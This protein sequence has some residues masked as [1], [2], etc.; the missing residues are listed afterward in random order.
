M[1]NLVGKREL[2]KARKRAEIVDIATRS[3]FEHGYA[4]TSMSSIAE[5]LGGSKTTLWSH[6][7]SKADL[8]TAVVDVQVETFARDIDE[9]LTN[10]SFSLAALRRACLRFLDCLLRENSV[11]LFRIVVSEGERF[12]EIAEAFYSRGPAKVRKCIVDFYANA[13]APGD[14]TRLAGLTMA[15]V[16]GFRADILLRTAKPTQ[17]EREA[18]VDTLIQLIDWPEQKTVAT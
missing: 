6:F 13:F 15:A 16:T 5:T 18:F 8:F 2:N 11:H 10:Q 12:P 14:A 4:A 3:F 1:Q 17:D 9:V 7:S